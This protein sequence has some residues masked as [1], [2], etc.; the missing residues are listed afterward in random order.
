MPDHAL[1]NL[2][3][4]YWNP[5]LEEIANIILRNEV[6]KDCRE[7]KI[8]TALLDRNFVLLF[9]TL[10]ANETGTWKKSSHT[11]SDCSHRF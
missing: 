2:A 8:F 3:L 1:K 6:K 10:V 9:C 11:S 4:K 5:T 7:M